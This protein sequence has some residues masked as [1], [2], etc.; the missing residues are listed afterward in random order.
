MVVGVPGL[1]G[2]AESARIE[3]GGFRTSRRC[4]VVLRALLSREVQRD[5]FLGYGGV[6]F[7]GRFL[8]SCLLTKE[9][10]CYVPFV[11]VL[12]H[13]FKQQCLAVEFF[14]RKVG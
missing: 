14:H 7:P 6:G 12:K 2:T 4:I 5:A 1:E 9:I 3:V 13:A 10:E 11:S 8:L